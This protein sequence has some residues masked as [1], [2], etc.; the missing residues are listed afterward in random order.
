MKKMD[1]QGTKH[2][3]K[4]FTNDTPSAR[5]EKMCSIAYPPIPGEERDCAQADITCS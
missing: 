1:D 3:I 4:V 2:E 5:I